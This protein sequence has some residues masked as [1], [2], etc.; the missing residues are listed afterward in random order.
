LLLLPWPFLF[1]V[2]Y[3]LCTNTT[4]NLF[5][6]CLKTVLT[7]LSPPTPRRTIRLLSDLDREVQERIKIFNFD[8]TAVTEDFH[9]KN[10]AQEKGKMAKWVKGEMGKKGE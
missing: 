3:R 1:F 9:H 10:L 7:H 5:F 4:G 6:H 2:Y 8:I